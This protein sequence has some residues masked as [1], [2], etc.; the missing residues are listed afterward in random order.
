MFYSLFLCCVFYFPSTI[1]YLSS[2]NFN[3][4]FSIF[5]LI[6]LPSHA[7]RWYSVSGLPNVPFFFSHFLT[8]S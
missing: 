2:S 1:S 8:T 3:S 7:G 4:L 6:F 5:H